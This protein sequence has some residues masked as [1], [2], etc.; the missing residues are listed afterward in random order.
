MPVTEPA[1]LLK[2]SS[3]GCACT[4][5]VFG[6]SRYQLKPIGTTAR[7]GDVHIT[8]ILF[9]HTIIMYY[10][11]ATVS[12]HVIQCNAYATI[13]HSHSAATAVL[14]AICSRVP[15]DS[16]NYAHS[17]KYDIDRC[18]YRY[19]LYANV[20]NTTI[21]ALANITHAHTSARRI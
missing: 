14:P 11:S 19:I 4:Y 17:D 13:Y 12:V 5:I 16:L 1:T 3:N 20:G 10:T 8:I 7:P 2:P 21:C 6:K 15:L 9:I 18:T